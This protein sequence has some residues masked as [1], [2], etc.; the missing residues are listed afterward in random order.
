MSFEKEQKRTMRGLRWF[1]RFRSEARGRRIIFH[2]DTSGYH[3]QE[4]ADRAIT[5]AMETGPNTRVETI[6]QPKRLPRLR[7]LPR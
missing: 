7:G 3:N 6:A 1:W 2:G 5:I 4:D